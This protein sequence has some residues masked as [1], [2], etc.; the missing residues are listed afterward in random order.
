MDLENL[1]G[2][3]LAALESAKCSEGESI[4][5]RFN[6][7]QVGEIVGQIVHQLPQYPDAVIDIVYKR[8]LS[9]FPEDI[10]LDYIKNESKQLLRLLVTYKINKEQTIL[11]IFYLM[12]AYK[13]EYKE[14]I[15]EALQDVKGYFFSYLIENRT[16]LEIEIEDNPVKGESKI[17]GQY[18]VRT[19]PFEVQLIPTK[20]TS[21]TFV[22]Y[23]YKS[24][25]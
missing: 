10:L 2:E 12:F 21:T 13:I 24:K 17:V 11:L 3:I 23:L 8:V 9:V 22:N 4:Y 6:G 7:L 18:Y 15:T 20:E 5:D 16:E 14:S 1:Q 19:I 25:S